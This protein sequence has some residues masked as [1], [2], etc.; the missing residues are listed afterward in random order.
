MFRLE[1]KG[2]ASKTS[3]SLYWD[4]ASTD[5]CELSLLDF[6]IQ[7]KYPIAYNCYGE[8]ICRKCILRLNQQEY[9]SCQIHMK[10]IDD[11]AILEIPYL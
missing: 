2:L 11:G 10:D 3:T 5:I 4:S 8:G 6:L 7:N 1:I 9:L